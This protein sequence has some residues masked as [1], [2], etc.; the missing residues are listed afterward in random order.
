MFVV[1]VVLFSG[2][3][4]KKL[5]VLWSDSFFS[6]IAVEWEI[7]STFQAVTLWVNLLWELD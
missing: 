1:A 4:S 3:C 7:W 5:T 2:L 6:G